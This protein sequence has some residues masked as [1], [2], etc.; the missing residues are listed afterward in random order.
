MGDVMSRKN[1]TVVAGAATLFL[2]LAALAG[3]RVLVLQQT[4]QEARQHLTVARA[5]LS[6]ASANPLEVA[7]TGAVAESAVVSACAEATTASTALQDVHTQLEL[8]MPLVNALE[9]APGVGAQ[10]RT[11]T[12]TLEAGTQVAA[13]GA[14]L[15][16]GLAP[17]ASLLS[18]DS[19]AADSESAGDILRT[20]V[21][22]RPKL[23]GA[24]E[25]LRQLEDSL[26]AVQVDDL[27]DSNRIALLALRQRLPQA[28]TTLEDGTVLLDLLGARGTR[29]YLLVSQNPDELRATGGFIGSAGVVEISGGNIRLVEYGS[30]RRYDTPLDRRA[31]PPAEFQDYLGSNSWNLAAAN[32]WV[33]FPDV[34]RQLAYFYSLS[35]P[36][37]PVDGVIA[38]DQFGLEQLLA[39]LGPV[40]VPEYGETV[41]S[42]EVESKLDRYVHAGGASNESG[43]K[44]FTAALS[45]AVL[46]AV[47]DAPRG[48][49]PGLAKA[50]R[51]SLDQ[52]HLLVWVPD[53]EAARLLARKHWDDGLLTA[54]SD[55]LLLVD[56]DVVGSKQSQAV[57]R[58]ASYALNL[59]KPATPTASLTITYTNGS[60]PDQRPDI[61]FVPQYRTFVR[62]VVPSGAQLL[63]TAGFAGAVSADQECGRRVFGG[64]VAIPQGSSVQVSL[65]YQLPPSV[66]ADGYDLV[67]QQQPGVPPG[68]LAVAIQTP[69]GPVTRVDL[70]NS[71][72]AHAHW[73]MSAAE[74][75][76]LS[77][78]PL[79]DEVGSCEQGLVEAR[80]VAP[81]ESIEIPGA[82]ISGR[83]VELGVS[84]D[85]QMEAPPT[86][87]V[88]GWYRM[89]AR[90]GEPGNSVMAGHL[91]WGQ[92]TGA[93][94]GLHQLQQGDRIQV[95]GT[96]G[97]VH[98]YAVEWNHV[99]PLHTAPVDQLVGPT[100]DSVLTL[101]TSD[102]VL[103]TH[104]R[105]YP[106]RR[107]VRARLAD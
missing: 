64:E 55:S 19:G 40:Q 27:E 1:V 82:R 102:G 65:Q 24:T 63:S 85:G 53:A 23:V 80:P 35:R 87:D 4:A 30:S 56:T 69:D 89:S 29:R 60:G 91:D 68:T 106:D 92:S 6:E 49:L 105:E 97:N 37:Q 99:F 58:D 66:S 75:P 67:I 10:A 61:S 103:D 36:R 39:V 79:P 70:P 18:G 2:S 96:D 51:A 3:W 88:V 8:V 76:S 50:V 45:E 12:E 15:C 20:L 94:W 44:Q 41:A 26:A 13:A 21:G 32:W 42:S 31:V 16:N 62:A 48:K 22:A 78:A 107:V 34:A 59:T 38:L 43:R 100:E 98:T 86:P 71:P 52:Q 81:P 47:L 33:S 46:Q 57:T 28:I 25:R 73:R 7:G 74:M 5:A 17:L 93:F 101:I 54:T 9:G 14:S 84:E 72:G 77:A 90:P 11:Q 95:R 83:I 104:S